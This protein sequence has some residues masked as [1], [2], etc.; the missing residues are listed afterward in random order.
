MKLFH[1]H[2][3]SAVAGPLSASPAPRSS[4]LPARAAALLV[5]VC[6][7][8]GLVL[9]GDLQRPG[10]A[11]AAGPNAAVPGSGC[12]LFGADN[13]WNADI[14]TLPLD[15]GAGALPGGNLH[16]DLGPSPYGIPFNVVGTSHP[17]VTKGQVAWDYG[18]ETDY[19]PYA[20]GPDIQAE[21][22]T[23]SHVLTVNRDTCQLVEA[24][25]AASFAGS[26]PYR[27]GSGATW[28]LNSNALRPDGW[29]SADAAGLPI[30]PGLVRYDEVYGAGTINH[31]IRFTLAHTRNAHVWPARHDAGAANSSYLPMGERLRLRAS[32]DISGYPADAQVVLR[33]MQHYG[34]FVTDNGSNWYFQ[35]TEDSRWSNSFIHSF[36]TVP[37]SAFEPV[38]ESS[39]MSDPNSATVRGG[40]GAACGPTPA[41]AAPAPPVNPSTFYFAEGFTGPGFRECIDLLMPGQTGTATIDY[42]TETGHSGPFTVSVAAGQVVAED[43][44]ARLGAGHDVSARVTFSGPGVAERVMRFNRGQGAGWTGSTDQVGVGAPATEWDFAEGSTLDSFSEFLTLQ[45]PNPQPVTATLN[46]L[47]QDFA[48]PAPVKT[49]VVPANSRSTV[50]VFLGETGSHPCSE[51]ATCG[52]GRGWAGV[53]V[54]ITTAG[55]PLIA[56]RPMYV[57]GCNCWGGGAIWDG[58]DSFGATAP[59]MAWDF[60]EGT[61]GA[62]FQEYLTVANPDPAQ[63]ATVSASFYF[64]PGQPPLLQGFGI[65]P[66]SRITIP[67]ETVVG[68]FRDVSIHLD[69]SLPV[70]A[71][72]PMYM[73]R[74]FGSG[75]VAGAHDG[76]GWNRPLASAYSFATAST[77]PGEADFLTFE[78]PGAQAAD[79][80]IAYFPGGRRLLSVGPGSRATV[81]LR[82]P[83]G[84]GPNLALVGISIHSSRPLLAEKPTYGTGY[85]TYGAT[86]TPGS[87]G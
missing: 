17:S 39:L 45:N 46:Y 50:D 85:W 7:A 10:V 59:A 42:F 5:A 2:L 12:P 35:G 6:I 11:R 47:L 18:G 27:A 73:V 4:S 81:D 37:G 31:A 15:P 3:T 41:A 60:A 84:P 19:G 43:V 44:T 74:D 83:N 49:V 8:S 67:V 23:D 86:V 9:T 75:V 69:S 78:N 53:G 52:V 33:A 56:E 79:V 48:G 21:G 29:T 63:V 64:G 82:G 16:A 76:L 40:A 58:H 34:M 65:D 68:R 87:P 1:N 24:F 20:V 13:V 77:I 66:H 61:T 71:E 55:G 62:G 51:P 28:D 72:R 14:S 57:N 30:L 25:A 38:D 32:F 36:D 70:V 26:G 80:R 22:P 54:K